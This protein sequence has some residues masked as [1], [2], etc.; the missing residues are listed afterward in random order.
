MRRRA[1]L[2]AAD[3]EARQSRTIQ[4]NVHLV[5]VAEADDV[6]VD[7][8]LQLHANRVFAV[9]RKLVRNRDTAAR[10]ERQLLA[11]AAVLVPVPAELIRD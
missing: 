9:D 8:R 6:V 10:S 7:V 1:V 11:H 4:T 2:G 5:P 3:G